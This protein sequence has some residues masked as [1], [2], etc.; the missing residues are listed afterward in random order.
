MKR[1]YRD[2]VLLFAVFFLASG[3]VSAE[4]KFDKN[5]DILGINLSMTKEQALSYVKSKYPGH[6]ITMVPVTFS[7]QNAQ[8]STTAGF[9]FQVY[10]GTLDYASA[11]VPPYDRISVIYNPNSNGADIYAV[12]RTITYLSDVCVD[13][14]DGKLKGEG[15]WILRNSALDELIKKYGNPDFYDGNQISSEDYYWMI[16][17]DPDLKPKRGSYLAE[18]GIT[19]HFRLISSDEYIREISE[20]FLDSY[21]HMD[22]YDDHLVLY[23]DSGIILRVNMEKVNKDS[24]QYVGSLH[25]VLIDLTKGTQELRDFFNSMELK[26]A[27]G[28]NEDVKQNSKNRPVF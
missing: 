23:K 20:N 22:S 1:Y 5:S 10:K 17:K 6:E 9:L 7:M 3:S 15:T 25:M 2:F 12:S 14:K 21:R 11:L 16:K 26:N 19:S 4:G 24:I 8:V 28:R 13:R 18:P 27:K